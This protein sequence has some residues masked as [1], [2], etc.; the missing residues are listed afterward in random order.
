MS[1]L[2]LDGFTVVSLEQAVAAP[3][4]TRLLADLGA[5]VIKVERV[6]GGDFARG[7]DGAV[8]GLAS[9][10]FWLNRSKESIALDVRG[11]AGQDVLRRLVAKADVL[12]Q[13]LAPGAAARL[14]LAADALRA[15]RPELVVADLSGYGDDGPYRDRKAYD[16]LVQAEAGLVSVTGT[17]DHPA[18]TGIPT[19]DI[20][21]GLHTSH[22]ILAALLRRARTGVGASLRISMFDA[23]AEWMGHPLYTALYGGAA[24]GRNGLAHPAIVPYDAYPTADGQVLIGVQNDR[25]WVALAIAVD[26]PDLA[27]DLELATNRQRVAA[28]ARLDAEVAAAT[29]PLATDV[30][31]AR[32][33]AAGVPAAQITDVTALA[34]HPQLADPRRWASVGTE[35]GRVDAVRPPAQFG[36]VD[37]R[38]DPVPGHGEHTDRLLGEIGLDEA[39]I[40]GLRAQKVIA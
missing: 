20:A 13:N 5:R 8:R 7:Y 21:A 40:A 2:P 34:A 36:D 22:A 37:A 3:F 19:A 1:G 6:D 26:R 18:K 39:T 28:R 33:A 35:V 27:A 38:M 16:M 25:Q 12:V 17:A 29:R 30:L 15:A 32:L 31:L 24:V 9:H 10:F 4:A 23:L 11:P 14:G